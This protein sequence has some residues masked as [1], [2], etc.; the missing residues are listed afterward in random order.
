MADDGDE[1]AA[2]ENEASIDLFGHKYTF[3]WTE[4]GPTLQY[5]TD[6]IV[7]MTRRSRRSMIDTAFAGE[8][9]EAPSA[10][11]EQPDQKSESEYESFVRQA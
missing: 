6:G 9:D 11:S 7:T 10:A 4:S 5:T 1:D 2:G 8:E 3:V